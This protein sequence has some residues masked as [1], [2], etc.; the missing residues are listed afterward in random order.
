MERTLKRNISSTENPDWNGAE[1]LGQ[2]ALGLRSAAPVIYG[3]NT[4]SPALF[5]GWAVMP[6]SIR[7][8]RVCPSLLPLFPCRIFY[9][10]PRSGLG[11]RRV[12]RI[13]QYTDKTNYIHLFSI[14]IGNAWL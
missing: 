12:P 5:T 11:M 10:N 8:K 2:A 3:Y 14:Y 4:V 6:H 13:I 1:P 7:V 9:R